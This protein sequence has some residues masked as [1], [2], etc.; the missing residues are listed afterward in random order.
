MN[1]NRSLGDILIVDDTPDNLRLLSSLLTEHGYKVR[2]VLDGA[3]AL[4]SVQL[5]PPDLILLDI[6][7]PVLNGYEVCAKLKAD[8]Q[9]CTIPVIFLSAREE[10]ID[11]VEAF[12]VGG[13]DYIT[14]PFQIQEVVARIE[15]QLQISRLQ[16]QLQERNQQLE[17]EIQDRV[18]A[19]NALETWNQ[20]LEQRVEQRTIE[21]QQR[22]QQLVCLQERLEKAL[23]QEHTLN[24]LK[25][26]LITTISHEFRT[27]LS[28]ITMAAELLRA[29]IPE[30]FSSQYSRYLQ[31]TRDCIHRITQVIDDTVFLARSDS[32][33][34]EC[35]PTLIDLPGFC[36]TLIQSWHLPPN[37][38]H[39]L[40]FAGD[41]MG[42][43]RLH[44]CTADPVLLNQILGHLLTNAMR[45]SPKGGV[46]QLSLS[47]TPEAALLQV[48][49]WGIGIPEAEQQKIFDRFYR[50]KNACSIPGT[51]GV[52][53]GLAVVKRLVELHHGT[54]TVSSSPGQGTTF[55]VSLP[56]A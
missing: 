11:K 28:S 31:I 47:Y 32:G 43:H 44:E 5:K 42:D 4:R 2:T 10:T 25:S 50:A 56:L 49:D 3:L 36:Q 35:N 22:N 18:A 29:A 9:T 55:T 34:I 30:S 7:M 48:Q 27:P 51:P 37:S 8:S 17:R 52:G 53:L 13:A 14:K 45:Y 19:Q 15:N 20:Q 39:H 12:K 6:M 46:V 38:P 40:V 16:Q 26:Q 21:L 54:I 23:A 24:E 1:S 41:E 33:D